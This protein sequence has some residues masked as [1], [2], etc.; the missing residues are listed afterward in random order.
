MNEPIIWKERWVQI[1]ALA[2]RPF[3]PPLKIKVLQWFNGTEYVDVPVVKEE[4]T[5]DQVQKEYEESQKVKW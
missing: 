4:R 1:E 2:D 3:G 5:A